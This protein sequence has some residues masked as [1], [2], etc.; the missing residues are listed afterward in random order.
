MTPN[1]FVKRMLEELKAIS[2]GQSKHTNG[3]ILFD[4]K[5]LPFCAVLDRF[6]ASPTTD[7]LKEVVKIADQDFG[8][9]FGKFVDATAEE[10]RTSFFKENPT[11]PPPPAPEI[12]FRQALY[13]ELTTI[14]GRGRERAIDQK[15]LDVLY[16]DINRLA[17]V[18]DKQVQK[19]AQ[20]EA[21]KVCELAIKLLGGELDKV[22]AVA[23]AAESK[24]ES[25]K[26]MFRPR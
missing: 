8:L 18:L 23:A 25:T 13:S 10:L 21:Q 12:P 14:L 19:Q 16:Q 20:A 2:L 7:L 5:K 3:A 11:P 17:D 4:P 26:A 24:A 22:S 1:D 9:R 6:V 15:L